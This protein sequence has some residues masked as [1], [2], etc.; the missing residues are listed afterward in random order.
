MLSLLA[1]WMMARKYLENWLLWI[2]VDLL[3]IGVY[4]VKGLHAT[5]ALYVA[6]LIMATWGLVAWWRALGA[7]RNAD[8]AST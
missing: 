5:A 6:F 8:V 2:A 3:G 1:Q 7:K 4:Q